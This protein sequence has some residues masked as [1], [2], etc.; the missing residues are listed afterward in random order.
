MDQLMMFGIIPAA[1]VVVAGMVVRRVSGRRFL[2]F[3]MGV[4]AAL[5]LAVFVAG[6]MTPEQDNQPGFMVTT[7]LAP[8]SLGV[9]A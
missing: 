2:L 8:V 4:S 1:L 3:L 5:L 7:L 9:L 6:W